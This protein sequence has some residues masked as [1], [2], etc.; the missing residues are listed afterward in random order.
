MRPELSVVEPNTLIRRDS[1]EDISGYGVMST[2]VDGDSS[3]LD[4]NRD[5]AYNRLRPTVR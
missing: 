2:Y 5:P 4:P 3:R 1:I